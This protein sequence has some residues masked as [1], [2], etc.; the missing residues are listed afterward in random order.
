[1]DSEK[2]NEGKDVMIKFRIEKR[3]KE[4]WKNIC[5]SKKISLSSLII[6]SVENKILDDERRKILMFIE[7]QDNIFAKIENNINQIARHVNVQKFISTA[8]IKVFNDKLDLITNL[9]D[10]QNKIFEKIYKLIGN[11]S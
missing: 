6:D 10:Q 7:K 2:K 9:K 3:K 5:Y 11:D 4:K 8:D 1:M